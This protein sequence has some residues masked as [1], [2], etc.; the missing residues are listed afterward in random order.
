MPS[1]NKEQE[2]SAPTMDYIETIIAIYDDAIFEE[3]DATKLAELIAIQAGIIH[4][5]R[6]VVVGES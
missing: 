4:N 5:F 1:A 6:N 3:T 2:L